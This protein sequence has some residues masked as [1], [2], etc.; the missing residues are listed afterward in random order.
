MLDQSTQLASAREIGD[1][2]RSGRASA[3]DVCRSSLDRIKAADPTLH[4]FCSIGEQQGITRASELDARRHELS[5]L[6]LFGVP[7]ALKDNLCTRGLRTTAG[8]RILERYVP[9]F[10]ATV[11]ERLDAAGAVIIG[12]TNCDEFAM[13][14]S[15]ENS[16][17]GPSR[18]PWALDRIPGGS[19]GGSAVAVAA[20]WRRSRSGRTPADRSASR[21]R[22]AASSGSSRPTGA[23]RA[24]A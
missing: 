16:A 7:V 13:G 6:P 20:G 22:S 19:S 24:T 1:N 8:S 23:C 18:N 9:P 12:K 4:A 11:V 17:F 21:P 2:L 14:S 15:T 10:D 5:H 3:A